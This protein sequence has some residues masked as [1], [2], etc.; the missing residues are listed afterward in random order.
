MDAAER[1]AQVRN[2]VKDVWNGRNYEAAADLYGDNYVNPFGTGPSARVSPSAATTPRSRTCTLMSKRWSRPA[3]R[4][5][6]GS[7]FGGP[8]LEVTWD[9][10]RPVEWWRSGWLTSC[11][12]KVTA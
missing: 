4:S 11:T 1:G 2:F 5:W 12:S 8:T 6:P 10:R 7:H 3:T 9:D